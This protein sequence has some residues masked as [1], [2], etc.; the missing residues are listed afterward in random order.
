MTNKDPKKT[1]SGIADGVLAGL[2]LWLF[3]MFSFLF[4]G[5]SIPMSILLGAIGGLAGA[6]VVAFWKSKDEPR[7]PQSA[8][9]EKPAGIYSKL[10]GFRLA[11]LKRDAKI[12]KYRRHKIRQKLP[13]WLFRKN[14]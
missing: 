8:I 1:S 4:L 5:Y 9:T 3:F 12:K 14:S 11:K 13:S 6:W 2:K 7:K 10:S